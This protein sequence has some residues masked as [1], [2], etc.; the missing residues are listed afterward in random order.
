MVER[1][2]S[3]PSRSAGPAHDV[4]PARRRVAARVGGVEP[5]DGGQQDEQVG[6]DEHGDLRGQEVV[7]AEGDVRGRRRVVLVDDRDDAP[8]QQ[9]REGLAG[10]EVLGAGADVVEGQQHLGARQSAVAQQLVV[11]PVELALPDRAGG[12]EVLDRGRAGAEPHDLQP[13]GDRAARDDDDLV[14]RRVALGDDVA[15]P[16]EDVRAQRAVVARH[17]PRAELDDDARHPWSQDATVR[18]DATHALRRLRH[19]GRRLGRLRPRA[20][21]QRGPRHAG[22]AAGG[23]GQ[24]PPP[25][26]EDPGR[27]RQAVP[28]EARL[29]AGDRARGPLRRPLA[30]RPPRQGPRRVLLDERDALRPRAAAGLRPLG[31]PGR[32]RLGLGRR[33]PVLPARRG[34]RA[35]RLRAP[36]R[37]RPAARRRRALP[38]AADARLPAG[39]PGRRRARR[40]RLQR[41]RAG[42]R[43]PRPGHPARRAALEHGRRLPASSA[44]PPQPRG[45]DRRARDRPG[46]RRRPGRRGALPR[47]A[48]A[49]A[50][51]RA[52]SARSC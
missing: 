7:V 26:R 31:G 37:G 20:P 12:L 42:R 28:D 22:A 3:R 35:W 30:L 32:R 13:P 41:A 10:V 2:T 1:P 6:A 16:G 8:G 40:A 15:D 36:R 19:R 25:Q 9:P 23:G 29:G 11:D 43:E 51:R 50:G 45:R 5:V 46:P 21:P 27:L 38:A 44:R 52:P 4:D 18:E 49:R 47:P 33:A 24:G 39:R 14:A 17:H 34:Q 48:R